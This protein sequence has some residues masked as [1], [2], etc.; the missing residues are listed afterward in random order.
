MS[1][2]LLQLC[3]FGID[4]KAESHAGK[5]WKEREKEDEFFDDTFW[6]LVKE[7]INT[8]DVVSGNAEKIL[9]AKVA[10]AKEASDKKAKKMKDALKAKAKKAPVKI[11]AAEE[12]GA[13]DDGD[14]FAQL[15]RDISIPMK[16][17]SSTSASAPQ[18]TWIASMLYPLTQLGEA[19]DWSTWAP[20]LARML[21]FAEELIL[22]HFNWLVV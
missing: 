6:N 2:F 14:T 20:F 17:V 5:E 22:Y 9:L 1:L 8:A 3:I 7:K 18:R 16:I 21:Y 10:S 15:K 11:V 13:G 12:I 4:A 19:K